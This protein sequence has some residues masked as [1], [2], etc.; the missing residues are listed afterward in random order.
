MQLAEII[1]SDT[2]AEHYTNIHMDID[3]S[4]AT[5]LSELSTS[6]KPKKTRLDS[7][8]V[9]TNASQKKCFDR[10]IAK[11]FCGSNISFRAADSRMFKGMVEKLHLGYNPP[12]AK[13]IAGPLL[14]N[15]YK[16]LKEEAKKFVSVSMVGLTWHMMQLLECRYSMKTTFFL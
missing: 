8:V 3:K 12:N 5:E 13:T 14:E 2:D 6:I 15:V 1:S 16:K 10:S 7:F 9:N 4:A 11:F